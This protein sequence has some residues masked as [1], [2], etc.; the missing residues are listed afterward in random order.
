[1]LHGGGIPKS[2]DGRL[3]AYYIAGFLDTTACNHLGEAGRADLF[4][5]LAMLQRL[6][7]LEKMDEKNKFHILSVLDGFLQS[8]KIKNI[9]V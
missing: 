6:S 4:L 9:A 5:D 2:V 1:M 8:V 7:D 3:G